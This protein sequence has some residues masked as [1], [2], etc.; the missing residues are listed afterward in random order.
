[1]KYIEKLVDCVVKKIEPLEAEELLDAQ[2][3]AALTCCVGDVAGKGISVNTY[4]SR[5]EK[6]LAR[7]E[8]AREH[9]R[10][11]KSGIRPILVKKRATNNTAENILFDT[12]EKMG[13]IE[14][15][16]HEKY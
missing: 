5:R 14:K 2:L 1:M 12:L 10:L 3:D 13:S 7:E 15:E 8:W 11:W 4:I 16:A 9:P 6:Y